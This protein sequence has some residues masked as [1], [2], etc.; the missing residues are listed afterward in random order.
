[1]DPLPKLNTKFA[2]KLL[3][4]LD[5]DTS[6]N[7]FLSPPSIASS[8][9]MTLLGAKENTARQIRQVRSIISQQINNLN[10]QLS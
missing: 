5:D 10:C 3:K 2:F 8:L 7:I 6:K 9:A 1:M 4:A